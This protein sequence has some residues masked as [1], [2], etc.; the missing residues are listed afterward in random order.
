MAVPLFNIGGLASGLDTTAII[1][2][3][4]DLERLPIQQLE[5][6]KAGFEQ[7]DLAWQG[8]TTRF[9]A[10]RTS[11]NKLDST[12]DID[13]FAKVATSNETAVGVTVSGSA[14]PGTVSFT[15]DQ[16]ASNQQLASNTTFTDP[17]DL[18]G[19][20]DFTISVGGVDSTVTADATTTVANLAS[21]INGL[22]A[23]VTASVI[24][25]TDGA[26][27]LLLSADDTGAAS[28]FTTNTAIASLGTMDTLQI[29]QDALVTFG[30][31]AG[32][33]QLSRS[34][35]TVTDLL[36]GVSI[37]LKA[38]TTSAVSVSTSRDIDAAKEAITTLMT[39]INATLTEIADLTRYSPDSD[40]AGPLVG[41][42]TARGLALTLRSAISGSVNTAS[43]D[44]PIASSVGISLGRDGIFVI[45]DTKLSD[46]LADDF[47][48]VVGLLVQSGS[49]T[50]LRASFS[51]AASATVEGAYDI[52][53]TQAAT[54]AGVTGSTYV[55][56]GADETFN[57]TVG[58]NV[59]SVTITGGS[60]A[61]DAAS[62]ISAALSSAGIT[63]YS[64]SVT[65]P[66]TGDALKI[67][68]V[69]YGAG[70]SVTIAANSF[71]LAGTFSGTDVQGT[72]GGQAA[73]GLGQILTGSAGDPVGLGVLVS[74]TA[75]DVSGAG[76]SL[77]LGTL[78]Y[79]A[80]VFG[81]VDS[82]VEAA[83]GSG[84]SLSRARDRWQSQI[85]LIDDRIFRLED[86]LD[87]KEALLIKQ[88]TALEVA[89][90]SLSGLNQY[91]VGALAGLPSFASTRGG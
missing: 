74:A 64:V 50:D 52:V 8:L 49:S 53:I 81:A 45:D 9:S 79:Q 70:H 90:S 19:A 22:D 71:G 14:P 48:A 2:Q 30:S 46:A 72:I 89:M 58:A 24:K 88:Y 3:L 21:M 16:L 12:A 86:R 47:D 76:G 20:G 56:P 51:S 73:S 39:D 55:A 42:S 31:G 68:S 5:F 63:G 83:E 87:Y 32:A 29:G 23:G 59:A 38:T 27:K 18:V 75:A 85:D 54:R 61:A 7:K 15:V 65:D 37:E 4:M 60:T 77:S 17:T 26:Y 69:G 36:A 35:N 41:D 91:L 11:L 13:K 34:S 78:T 6:R 82:V 66:G 57:I 62:A 25:V 10:I 67:Q 84:G 33:L 44:Y 40:S 80:G 43:V 1:A 28:A